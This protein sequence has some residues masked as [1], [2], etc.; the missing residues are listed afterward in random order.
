VAT[1]KIN[2][3]LEAIRA[4]IDSI[5]ANIQTLINERAKLAQQ[6]GISKSSSG[7]AVDFY[8]PER[9][10]EVLRKAQKRNRGPLRDEEI[11]RPT[12]AAQSRISR[13][14]R[15]LCAGR[16]CQAFWALGASAAAAGHR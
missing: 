4:R 12:G 16:G 7:K 6:V 1:K 3:E 10:A 14:R 9:E 11:L 15:H 13:A 8:R 2:P 5:D